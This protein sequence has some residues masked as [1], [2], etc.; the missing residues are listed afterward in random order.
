MK[1]IFVQERTAHGKLVVR[2]QGEGV[3]SRGCL[4]VYSECRF[5]DLC[6][7]LVM[8][9]CG[10]LLMCIIQSTAEYNVYNVTM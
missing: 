3:R 4:G 5:T 9:C 10:A 2:Q 6:V 8:T 7:F 1:T